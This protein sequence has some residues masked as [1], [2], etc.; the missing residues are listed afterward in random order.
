MGCQVFNKKQCKVLR[1]KCQKQYNM[2]GKIWFYFSTWKNR[3]TQFEI[4]KMEG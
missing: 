2:I 1:L 4:M 3:K